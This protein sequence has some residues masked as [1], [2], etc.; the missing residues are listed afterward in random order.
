MSAHCLLLPC[1]IFPLEESKVL[2]NSV[3]SL[4]GW[5]LTPNRTFLL[6]FDG[7]SGEFGWAVV[8]I[9]ARRSLD[10][11]PMARIKE[12]EMTPQGTKRVPLGIN[13][14]GE[15]D[16]VPI[17]GQWLDIAGY[18]NS[19]HSLWLANCEVWCGKQHYICCIAKQCQKCT[20]RARGTRSK[21][22]M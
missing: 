9:L 8:G 11:I 14:P 12:T 4:E 22:Q 18:Q 20:R 21:M 2:N 10:K 1:N 19:R 5:I 13:R 6:R 17:S 16:I 15:H 7:K 3:L